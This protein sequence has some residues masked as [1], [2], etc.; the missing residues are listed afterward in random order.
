MKDSV[1][2]IFALL[3][4]VL[5]FL[6]PSLKSADSTVDVKET[7]EMVIGVNEVTLVLMGGFKDGVQFGDFPAFWAHYQNDA[8]F[9]AALKAAWDN[10]QAIPA[11]IKDIDVGEGLELAAV[12]LEY[13]PKMLDALKKEEVA[14]A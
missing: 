7:K 10:Y 5:S 12:Q 14:K 13:V 6:A 9:E 8:K 11:E 2:K 4:Q 1:K 3:V